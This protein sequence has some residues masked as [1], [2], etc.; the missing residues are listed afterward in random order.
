MS[1]LK[2]Y[3][4]DFV[5]TYLLDSRGNDGSNIIDNAFNAWL[6][7][8]QQEKAGARVIFEDRYSGSQI[9]DI[10]KQVPVVS[11]DIP[12]GEL[13]R[14]IRLEILDSLALEWCYRMM[15]YHD[16]ISDEKVERF[17]GTWRIYSLEESKN[18][19]QKI[20]GILRTYDIDN[21]LD[22]LAMLAVEWARRTSVAYIDP[23]TLGYNTLEANEFDDLATGY[24][25]WGFQVN[26]H[27]NL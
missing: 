8:I 27:V 9:S 22:F 16:A 4:V 15:Q 26:F 19:T 17:K 6:K 13:P 7:L 18:I 5:Y 21:G 10:N 2:T 14:E 24:R 12:K 25:L 3:A 11:I 23:T 20:L 1:N